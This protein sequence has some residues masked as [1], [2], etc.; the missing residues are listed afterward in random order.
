MEAIRRSPLSHDL[1]PE[2]AN[3]STVIVAINARLLTHRPFT[4]LLSGGGARGFA[5]AGAL[6]ALEFRGYHPSAI[7]GVSMGA[8]VG[9]SYTLHPDWYRA[10]LEMDTRAFPKPMP[11]AEQQR[12]SLR[13]RLQGWWRSLHFGYHMVTGWG[14]GVPARAAGMH[15]L[16]ALTLGKTLDMASPPLAVSATDLNA[17]RRHIFRSGDATDAIYASSALAGVLPPLE[18]EGC[19]LADGAYSDLAPMDVAR[20]FGHPVVIAVDPGQDLVP[21]VIRNGFQALTRAVEVCN[22][23]HATSGFRGADLVLRPDYRRAID[24]LDFAAR[25]ECIAAG[26]RSV[27]AGRDA[28]RALL[29]Q[30]PSGFDTPPGRPL[31]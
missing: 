31:A 5:H 30:P 15:A 19:L 12:S 28:L 14:I 2:S 7:V 3:G 1:G 11:T 17:G 13:H 26:A 4:L 27:R 20:S 18:I 29:D 21:T 24:T 23:T 10:L 8:V 22:R 16:R 9:G 6:R 25:R